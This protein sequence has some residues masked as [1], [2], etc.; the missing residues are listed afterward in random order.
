[1]ANTYWW[2]LKAEYLLFEVGGSK[3]FGVNSQPDGTF[4]NFRALKY[5]DRRF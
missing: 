2:E 1:M 4:C 5:V 3:H